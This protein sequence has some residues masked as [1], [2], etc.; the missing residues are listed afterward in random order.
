MTCVTIR[1]IMTGMEDTITRP[2]I[3]LEELPD[4][5]LLSTIWTVERILNQWDVA[6][7]G[8]GRHVE[9]FYEDAKH[10]ARIRGLDYS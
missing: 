4:K 1:D 9:E 2:D 10:E 7:L 6:I 5:G 8:S 3:N